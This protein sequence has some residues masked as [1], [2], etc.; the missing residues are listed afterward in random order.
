MQY[1]RMCLIRCDGVLPIGMRPMEPDGS[2]FPVGRRARRRTGRSALCL[3]RHAVKERQAGGLQSP[4]GRG[5]LP[6]A[7]ASP[8]GTGREQEHS[9]AHKLTDRAR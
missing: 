8:T 3:R 5:G 7:G 9:R 2:Q 1:D 4:H 6:T